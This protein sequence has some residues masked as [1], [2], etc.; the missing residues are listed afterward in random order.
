MSD[1]IRL[2]GLRVWG[3]HGA[4]P[5]ERDQTQPFDIDLKIT[6][7][8]QTAQLSDELSDTVNYA[9]VHKTVVEIVEQQ[10]YKLLER[11]AG[12]ITKSLFADERVLAVRITIAKPNLLEGTTPSVTLSRRNPKH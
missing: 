12:E 8:L 3:K 9:A 5:G 6:A 7:D 4:N 11:L 2:S 1:T 10:S